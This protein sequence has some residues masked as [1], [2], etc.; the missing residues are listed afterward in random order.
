MLLA[1]DTGDALRLRLCQ[2][3]IGAPNLV[4]LALSRRGLVLGVLLVVRHGVVDLSEFF[5]GF[6]LLTGHS[7]LLIDGLLVTPLMSIALGRLV[8]TAEVRVHGLIMV[9]LVH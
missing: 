6:L 7:H 5:D 8:G 3:R 2:T 4:Y 9:L 1:D